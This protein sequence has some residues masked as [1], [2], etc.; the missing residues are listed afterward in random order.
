MWP[1]EAASSSVFLVLLRVPQLTL[2]QSAKIGSSAALR[3]NK[4]LGFQDLEACG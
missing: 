1:K 3:T 2:A 4:W